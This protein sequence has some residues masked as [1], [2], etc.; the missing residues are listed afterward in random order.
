MTAPK[1]YVAATPIGN[2]GDASPRF[3]QVIESVDLVLAED[4]RR[5]GLLFKE[6]DIKPAKMISFFEHNEE[7]RVARVLENMAQGQSAALVSD[8]GT[9]LL[10]D[11]GFRLV[12]ACVDAGY[13]VSPIPGPSAMTAALSACGL[14][15]YPFTFLGFL[16]R[17]DARIK[18]LFKRH[19]DT[20]CTLIF[21]ER[22]DRISGTLAL[23]HEV[24]GKRRFCVAREITK[25]YE[26]FIHG[27]LGK[28]SSVLDEL[29]GEVTVVIESANEEVQT[30]EE[31]IRA[32]WLEE[33]ESGDKPKQVAKRVSQRVKG[34]T[35]KE[36]YEMIINWS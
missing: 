12:R 24:L 5:A 32:I 26:E 28:D 13:S 30:P 11:P 7:S 22:K 4:T 9:P 8:A 29:R 25:E 20:G 2:P 1:L 27:E 15:P 23:A 33:K 10:S 18:S 17:R 35:A 3:R 36:V 31:E 34:F 21:F 6:L 16:P 19:A 14:A